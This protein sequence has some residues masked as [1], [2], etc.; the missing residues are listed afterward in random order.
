MLEGRRNKWENIEQKLNKLNDKNIWFHVASLG[1]YE[2][3]R[4]C[5]GSDKN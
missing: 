3:A 5:Y 1:E 2:Q 4:T